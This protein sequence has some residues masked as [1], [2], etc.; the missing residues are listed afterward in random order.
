MITVTDCK[1]RIIVVLDQVF[2]KYDRLFS[3]YFGKT[4]EE[5][6][7]SY[8]TSEELLEISIRNLTN[9]LTI[10]VINEMSVKCNITIL[11]EQSIREKIKSTL[12]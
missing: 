1:H 7:L 9:I 10:S 12:K 11:S 3:D 4:S 5:I 2:P 6:L 8:P